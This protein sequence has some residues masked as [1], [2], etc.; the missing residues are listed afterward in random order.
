[1]QD[2]LQEPIESVAGVGPKT[3]PAFKSKGI[4]TVQDLLLY[5]PRRYDD[6]SHIVPIH[7]IRPGQISI[8]ARI[9]GAK[10]RRGRRGLSITEALASDGTD[11]VKL[12]WFNQP[13]RATA[14]KSGETYFISGAYKLSNRQYSIINPSVELASEV[15][16]NSARI[17][18][19]YPETKDLNSNQVRR[20]LSR[21]IDYC[22][23]LEDFMPDYVV[24]ELEQLPYPKAVKQIHFPSDAE[25]LLAAKRRLMFDNLFPLMLANEMNERE[26]KREHTL[27]VEFKV[28][29]ARKFVSEL[30]FRLTDDQRRVIWQ[31]YQDMEK[32]MPMNRLVEGDV[33]S[34]KTVVAVMA[35]VMAMSEGYKVAFMAPTELLARQHASTIERLLRPLGLEQ[36]LI[37]LTG[38]MSAKDKKISIAKA[39]AITGPFVVGTHS[40]LSSGIDWSNLAL[41]I[42]DEQHRFG[43]DQR[44]E[45]QKQAGRIPHFLSTT[46]TPIPRSLALTVLS[47]LN[48]S[49]LK[50]LPASRK[51]IKTELILPSDFPRFLDT[52]RSEI[53]AGRQAYVVAPYIHPKDAHDNLAAEAVAANLMLKLKGF[54]IRLLHGQ[55]PSAEQEEIMTAFLGGKIDLLVATTVIEVGVDVPNATIM[56]IYGP[57][58]FG[59]AQLHQLRGR[60]GRGEHKSSCFLMLSDSMAPLPRLRQFTHIEDGFELSELDLS[61]RGPGAIYGKLQHGKGMAELLTIDDAKLV[62]VAKKAVEL[63]FK[64]KEN[65]LKYKRLNELVEQAQR[66][67]YLN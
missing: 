46:A 39:N 32:D 15:P 62:E 18:P 4:L 53:K 67:T 49:R 66:L 11:S 31:I 54:R 28:D 1:M 23:N 2:P 37:T 29:L 51:P 55:L 52:V 16:L 8:K 42:I 56:A 17:V 5:F 36:A 13:Y 33:G 43:V 3:A 60:V 20:A 38:S 64:N 10:T 58:R 26:R 57:E 34:G 40:L 19:V 59:L 6:F 27:K 14:L 50:T 12:V 44:M 25:S 9:S 65:L 21:T 45:L 7:N 22:D 35:A 47:D 30:P 24:S 41:L 61:L 63:F 48:L